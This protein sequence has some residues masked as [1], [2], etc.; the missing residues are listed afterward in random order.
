MYTF[1]HVTGPRK[2]VSWNITCSFTLTLNLNK[3]WKVL[4]VHKSGY[5]Y[6]YYFVDCA[7]LKQQAVVW[8][9][10]L[11]AL[12]SAFALVFVFPWSMISTVALE[13]GQ[14]KVKKT[15]IYASRNNF[16]SFQTGTEHDTLGNQN[17]R[18]WEHNFS[19]LH[20]VYTVQISKI[21]SKQD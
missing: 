17:Y 4:G 7:N 18:W 2:S 15:L 5:L 6:L 3:L 16:V 1:Y 20:K 21:T 11:S 13:G 14:N 12:V 9:C 10:E 19:L 8:K